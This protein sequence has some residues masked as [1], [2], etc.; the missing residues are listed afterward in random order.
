MTHTNIADNL[1]MLDGISPCRTRQL[2]A[3]PTRHF[4]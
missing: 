4:E 1:I 3:S 2:G